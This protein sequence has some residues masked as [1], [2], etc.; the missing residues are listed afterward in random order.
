MNDTASEGYNNKGDRLKKDL[1]RLNG[2]LVKKKERRED[3][4]FTLQKQIIVMNQDWRKY[5]QEFH[6]G[7]NQFEIKDTFRNHLLLDTPDYF[8]KS[9]HD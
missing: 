7:F 6:S 1:S 4:E 9:E 8:L 2:K 5:N 3:L